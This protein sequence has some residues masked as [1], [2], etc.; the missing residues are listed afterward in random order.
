MDNLEIYNR[1]RSCPPEAMK[2]IGAGRL[3]GMS[4]INP[5]W[6]IKMLTEVFGMCGTG[7]YY[8]ITKQWSETIGNEITAFVNISLYVKQD[9]EWSM[10]IQGTGGSKL[11]TMEKN[12]QYVSDECYKMALTDAISVACK[13]LGMA[14]DVYYNKDQT[15]YTMDVPEQSAPKPKKQKEAAPLQYQ[16]TPIPPQQKK[17]TEQ[18]YQGLTKA[19]EERGVNPIAVCK[20]FQVLDLH[21]LDTE[22]LDTIRSNFMDVCKQ[23]KGMMSE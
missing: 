17:I 22:Q 20:L 3:K 12:G 8:E 18:Q 6:R 14:A 15:K 2:T 23:A 11:A 9:G 7:W 10:P 13:A 21:E 19:F 1:V 4:D 16:A 5:M